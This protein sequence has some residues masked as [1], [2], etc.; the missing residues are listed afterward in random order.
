ML[1]KQD[2]KNSTLS[3]QDSIFETLQTKAGRFF[4]NGN[5]GSFPVTVTGPPL[6]LRALGHVERNQNLEDLKDLGP[7]GYRWP[8]A[9]RYRTGGT[10]AS[11]TRR[12]SAPFPV[13][14]TEPQLSTVLR[15]TL[16]QTGK[17]KSGQHLPQSLY[18]RKQVRNAEW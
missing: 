11:N 10:G 9:Q 12:E 14:V 4:L 8:G 18:L 7:R 1:S 3:K 16:R 6:V 13:T 17:P 15:P 5:R 2:A